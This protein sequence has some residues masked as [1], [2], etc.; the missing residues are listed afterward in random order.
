MHII[1]HISKFI[2]FQKDCNKLVRFSHFLGCPKTYFK[3]F[4]KRHSEDFVKKVRDEFVA[5]LNSE[6]YVRIWN[7]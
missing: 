5:W 2:T 6:K 7:S 1:L 3:D 4:L